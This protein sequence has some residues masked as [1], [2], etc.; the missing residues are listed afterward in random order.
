[1]IGWGNNTNTVNRQTKQDGT[2]TGTGTGCVMKPTDKIRRQQWAVGITGTAISNMTCAVI[3]HG[4]L[5][6]N[7]SA[8]LPSYDDNPSEACVH[9]L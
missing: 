7:T 3:D 4:P 5:Q 9:P 1:M 2:G 8:Y 6:S